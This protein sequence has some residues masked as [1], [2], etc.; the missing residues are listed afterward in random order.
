MSAANVGCTGKV[1]GETL[2]SMEAWSSGRT[3]VV[4]GWCGDQLARSPKVA[5]GAGGALAWGLETSE[6]T[7]QGIDKSSGEGG[8][9]V[10]DLEVSGMEGVWR[11]R[12]GGRRSYQTR[13]GKQPVV[14]DLRKLGQSSHTNY[15]PAL[16]IGQATGINRK[17]LDGEGGI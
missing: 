5:R 8:G 15:E 3:W 2:G 9:G 12:H 7:G 14:G 17:G 1:T 6:G 11:S 16:I 10:R 13:R 4:R